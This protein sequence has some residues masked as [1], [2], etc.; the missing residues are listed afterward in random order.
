MIDR[1]GPEGMDSLMGMSGIDE[2]RAHAQALRDAEGPKGIGGIG[3]M[4]T[5][6]AASPLSH[7]ASGVSKYRAKK[8]LKKLRGKE[9]EG[10]RTLI[11]AL[12]RNKKNRQL[13]P[14]EIAEGEGWNEPDPKKPGLGIGGI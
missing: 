2:Q 12:F 8:D 4:N 5:Y 7:L 10:N 14:E 9:D 1:L 3:R 6:V 11:D 13:T